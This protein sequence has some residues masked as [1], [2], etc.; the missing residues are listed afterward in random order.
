MEHTPH[1][2]QSLAVFLHGLNTSVVAGR[3]STA[4]AKPAL[5]DLGPG[6]QDSLVWAWTTMLK[7]DSSLSASGAN[8]AGHSEELSLQRQAGDS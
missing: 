1:Y 2:F 6:L 3:L 4:L 7:A 8:E 5:A